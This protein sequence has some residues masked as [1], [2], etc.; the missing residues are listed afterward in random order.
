MA[1]EFKPIEKPANRPRRKRSSVFVAFL[2]AAKI[3]AGTLLLFTAVASTTLAWRF[4][5]ESR[6]RAA[7]LDE[8]S[9]ALGEINRSV[10][11]WEQANH[12]CLPTIDKRFP[13]YECPFEQ[14]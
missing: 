14:R 6:T 3:V 11:A 5:N 1:L 7:A 2:D 13:L 4:E 10:T 12:E 9:A 8:V